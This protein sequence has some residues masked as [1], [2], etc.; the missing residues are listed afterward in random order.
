MNH[1]NAGIYQAYINQM[2]QCDTVAAFI[3]RPSKK[4]LMSAAT[5]MS[6]Y[7][8]PRAPSQ[9]SQQH[10]EQAKSE[11]GI[12]QLIE[13]RDMFM[14]EVCLES[15]SMRQAKKDRTEFYAMYT[16]VSAKVKSLNVLIR[17]AAGKH[18]RKTFFNEI[19]TLEINRQI[20]DE[21]SAYLDKLNDDLGNRPSPRLEER[22]VLAELICLDT[23][24]LDETSRFQHRLYATNMFVC[25][26][27]TREPPRP[28]G[29]TKTIPH[30][31]KACARNQCFFCY[32]NHGD[33]TRFYSVYRTRDHVK[34]HLKNYPEGSFISCPEPGCRKDAAMSEK[35]HLDETGSVMP[36]NI[37]TGVKALKNHLAEKHFYD[38]FRERF[39]E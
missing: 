11:Y 9:G 12:L 1:R 7:V 6:R 16:N 15:G 22:K 23:E 27:R 2:V 26:G 28:R 30:A 8:D 14:R 35:A 32:W 19:N 5:H 36:A 39:Q 21:R 18:T 24:D 38:I 20:R 17:K 29:P 31:H 4:A 10:L 34:L 3:G 33:D 37:L 25:L 13:L